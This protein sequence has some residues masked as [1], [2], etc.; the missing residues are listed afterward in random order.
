MSLKHMMMVSGAGGGGHTLIDRTGWATDAWSGTAFFRMIDG[1]NS[2]SIWQSGT[3]I[4]A[5]TSWVRIDMGTTRTV[6]GLKI[7]NPTT[8]GDYPKSANV[9][10][11]DDNSAWTTVATWTI[12]STSVSTFTFSWTPATHR[13]WRFL[14]QD[15]ANGAPSN[16]WSVGE[17][18]CYSDSAP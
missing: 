9:Q 15:V 4:V 8:P 1:D 12:S 11:S 5:G 3:A 2:T 7:E 16:W 13:Y 14:A 18:Y 6:G 10:Y 17:L